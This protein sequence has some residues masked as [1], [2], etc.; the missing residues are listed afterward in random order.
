MVSWDFAVDQDGAPVFIEANLN[1][2]GV[3]IN[4]INNGPLFGEDTKMILDEVFAKN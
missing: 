3:H 4:Q 2:G 1:V